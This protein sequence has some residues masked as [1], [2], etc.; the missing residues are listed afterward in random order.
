MLAR[1][2]H[3]MPSD[4]LDSQMETLEEPDQLEKHLTL[5]V[6][7]EPGDIVQAVCNYMSHQDA[8]HIPQNY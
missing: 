7:D 5:S 4:L 1:A 8:A 2:G 6:D 3:Y